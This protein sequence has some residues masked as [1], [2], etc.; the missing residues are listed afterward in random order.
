MLPVEL[1]VELVIIVISYLPLTSIT[2]LQR[3]DRQWQQFL[4][5]NQNAVYRNAAWR[6]G[7]IP[8][9]E[10]L[11]DELDDPGQRSYYSKRAMR[12]VL[13]WKDFCTWLS[14]FFFFC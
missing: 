5:Q 3:V 14:S 8:S 1:P 10:T 13:D 9:P 7:W 6:E 11:L 4:K 2:R 12:G